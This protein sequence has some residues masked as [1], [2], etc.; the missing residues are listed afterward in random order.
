MH[1]KTSMSP[2]PTNTKTS[3]IEACLQQNSLRDSQCDHIEK[4][5]TNYST[6]TELPKSY[7][8]NNTAVSLVSGIPITL[9]DNSIISFFVSYYV[10]CV[11]YV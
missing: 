5:I 1:E 10:N 6:I 3:T 7:T 8:E 11:L 9:Q 2:L 4:K